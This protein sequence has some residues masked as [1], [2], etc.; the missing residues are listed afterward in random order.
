MTLRTNSR[1]RKLTESSE[2]NLQQLQI[3]AEFQILQS[4]IPGIADQNEITEVN[5]G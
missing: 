4:L 2:N 3:Q 5:I 1:K